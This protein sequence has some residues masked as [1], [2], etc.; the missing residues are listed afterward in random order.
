MVTNSDKATTTDS[1]GS[2]DPTHLR[3]G[4]PLKKTLLWGKR[5]G[6]MVVHFAP[7]TRGF[8]TPT[9]GIRLPTC[10][11]ESAQLSRKLRSVRAHVSIAYVRLLCLLLTG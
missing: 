5:F 1:F 7:P 10:V 2:R 9:R 3:C 4:L 6:E 8:R 11:C